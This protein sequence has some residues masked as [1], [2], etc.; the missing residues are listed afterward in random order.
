[1]NTKIAFLIPKELQRKFKIKCVVQ[2]ISQQQK[3]INFISAYVREELII[4]PEQLGD[5]LTICQEIE[6]KGLLSDDEIKEIPLAYSEK[7]DIYLQL[8]RLSGSIEKTTG[9]YKSKSFQFM[10]K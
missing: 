3:M 5:I 4:D 2:N 7:L 9:G 8:M 6:S 10:F 1:M